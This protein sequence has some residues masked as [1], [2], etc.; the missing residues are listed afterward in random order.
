MWSIIFLLTS[1]SRGHWGTAPGIQHLPGDRDG[2]R[3]GRAVSPRVGVRIRPGAGN[4][5]Q[6]QS[7]DNRAGG[8]ALAM[9]TPWYVGGLLSTAPRRM[10]PPLAA[11]VPKIKPPGAFLTLLWKQFTNF[12]PRYIIIFCFKHCFLIDVTS[13]CFSAF[14]SAGFGGFLALC[15]VK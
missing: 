9:V 14:M 5:G 2:L 1:I 6:T 3:L 8:G 10:G 11:L 13:L 7:P 12:L 15:I 4:Q